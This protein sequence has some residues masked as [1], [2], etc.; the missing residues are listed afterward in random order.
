MDSTTPSTSAAETRG[1]KRIGKRTRWKARRLENKREKYE[2]LH[3]GP[4]QP[5]PVNTMANSLNKIRVAVD[6]D[7]EEHL[8]DTEVLEC[9][10]QLMRVH[11]RNRKA[12]MPLQVYFTSF[13]E[14]TLV[15]EALRYYY[16]YSWD[17]HFE[18]ESYL[19]VFE[20]SSIVYLTSDST[21]V[22]QELN[23][24]EVYIIGGLIRSTQTGLSLK[25]AEELGLRT[26]RLPLPENVP[27]RRRCVLEIF[28]GISSNTISIVSFLINILVT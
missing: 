23:P 18:K 11:T 6:L 7:Y 19:N 3:G 13:A 1:R 28:T 14:G 10:K 8:K 5:K 2:K 16:Y 12:A 24:N 22:L 25:R 26:A 4:R 21:T 27:V 17:I 9:A 20:K 15:A